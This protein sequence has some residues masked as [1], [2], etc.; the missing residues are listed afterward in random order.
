[1]IEIFKDRL[2]KPE[3]DS[4]HLPIPSPNDLQGKVIIKGKR[5]PANKDE[6][7][8]DSGTDSETHSDEPITP[9]RLNFFSK[10]E[11]V[12]IRKDVRYPLLHTFFL[13]KVHLFCTHNVNQKYR[14]RKYVLNQ[15][16]LTFFT[17]YENL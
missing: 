12:C 7:Y 8:S 3:A 9:R 6:E 17:P 13:I 4:L 10:N 14:P 15:I 5:F 1:M 11:K 16:S 2:Y